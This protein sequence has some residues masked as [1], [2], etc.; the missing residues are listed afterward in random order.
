MKLYKVRVQTGFHI[1]VK[2]KRFGVLSTYSLVATEVGKMKN[3]NQN[4]ELL[5]RVLNRDSKRL[6]SLFW[7]WPAYVEKSETTKKYLLE[8]TPSDESK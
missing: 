2:R 8:N 4:K 6:E 7:P 5:R 1:A 3:I